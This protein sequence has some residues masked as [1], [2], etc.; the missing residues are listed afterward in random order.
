MRYAE[1]F[2]KD[3]YPRHLNIELTNHCQLACV[4]CPHQLMT[5][6]QGFMSWNTLE[7]IVK[8]SVGRTKTCFAHM[9]GESLLH[10]DVDKMLAYIK[11]ETGMHITL[12]TNGLLLTEEMSE[13]LFDSGLDKLVLMV[14]SLHKDIFESIRVGSH[15]ETVVRNIDHCIEIRR[16]RKDVNTRLQIEM[17]NMYVNAGEFGDFKA[18][19]ALLVEDI[20]LCVAKTFTTYGGSIPVMA[21]RCDSPKSCLVPNCSMAIYW[22]GDVV[23]CCSDYDGKIILGNVLE[24]GIEE[25]WN[26]DRYEKYRAMIIRRDFAKISLCKECVQ[27]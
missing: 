27:K 1:Q 26:S 15:F 22:N 21:S 3:I 6:E 17:I 4:M 13:K 11:T 14:D 12:S 2:K 23:L 9:F 20:G 16:R 24:A 8:E 19:Y 5:R 25:I 18:K 7:K 10:S